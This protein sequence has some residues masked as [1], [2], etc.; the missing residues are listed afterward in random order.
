MNVPLL[1]LKPQYEALKP[2]IDAT[3]VRVIQS[4]Y[5]ILGPDVERME[6]EMASYLEAKYA[7]GVSSGTDALLLALMALNVGSGDEIIVP[8]FSFFATAGVVSRLGATPVFVDIDPVTY[9]V[10]PELIAD[11]IT[12]RTKGIIPVHL[13]GQAANLKPILEVAERH[14]IPVIEDAAQAIGARYADGKRLGAIGEVGCFSFFPS[15]NLGAFGDAGLV[16]TNDDDLYQR[17]KIMR[18]HGGERSYYHSVIGGNF[19]IDALQAAILSV[20]L[21]HLDRWTAGRRANANR[22]RGLFVESGLT[23]TVDQLLPREG[24]PVGL[25]QSAY[26]GEEAHIYNQFVVR[27]PDRDR[28]CN[29]LKEKGV[30][31]AIYYPV[32][33]H[34]QEC[35]ASL[36][37]RSED[38][39]EAE[40]AAAEVLALP[41]YPELV[42]AQQEYVVESIREFFQG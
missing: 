18:V 17:M 36:G 32:P 24:A 29:H 5:F 41:I 39:P 31:H 14:D 15:K 35:F 34:R 13:F 27:V 20:K 19:R 11:A 21:P 9:N 33:F 3:V 16:T 8:T 26:N 25:P 7:I 37:Y 42:P 4:Q 10:N 22:Y 38:F 30:G 23:D 12:P 28:L 6:G 2:E 40:R 1:D